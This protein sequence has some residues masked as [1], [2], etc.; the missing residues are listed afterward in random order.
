[1]TLTIRE[2]SATLPNFREFMVNGCVNVTIPIGA[3]LPG[4]NGGYLE[5]LPMNCHDKIID[6]MEQL[7]AINPS[8]YGTHDIPRTLWREFQ[9]FLVLKGFPL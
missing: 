2:I 9:G 6:T 5:P 3:P 4:N 7:G 8:V 1:M